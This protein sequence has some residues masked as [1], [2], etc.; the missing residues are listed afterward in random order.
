MNEKELK[1]TINIQA[2]K[3]LDMTP[4][5]NI[6]N[7]ISKNYILENVIPRIVS[8]E[9]NW[10]RIDE[11]K[12]FWDTYLDFAILYHVEVENGSYALKKDLIENLG[13]DK[14]ELINKAE[15]NLKKKKTQIIKLEDLLSEIMEQDFTTLGLP[16][17]KALVITAKKEQYSANRILNKELRKHIE[18]VYGE[19]HILLPSSV[20]EWILYAGDDI[21]DSKFREMVK[22]INTKEVEQEDFLSNNVYKIEKGELKIIE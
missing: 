14:E 3:A 20:H 22:E 19:N 4:E 13:I 15:E 6:K 21:D 2:K 1:E 12:L 18:E 9:K 17:I 5:Q 11:Q 8:F 7:I 16:E 10:K